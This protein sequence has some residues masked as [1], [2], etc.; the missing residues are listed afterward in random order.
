MTAS[1]KSATVKSS[2]SGLSAEQPPPALALDWILKKIR[3][4]ELEKSINQ[5]EATNSDLFGAN[6]EQ[7]DLEL[8]Q[9]DLEGTANY[10]RG[11]E[12]S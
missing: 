5:I 1:R 6:T 8:S 12:E 3:E 11:I 4:C 9:R 7:S 2:R 10:D